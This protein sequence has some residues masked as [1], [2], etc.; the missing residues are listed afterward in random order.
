MSNKCPT[1]GAPA[2]PTNQIFDGVYEYRG[3]EWRYREHLVP[4][5]HL[6]RVLAT[7]HQAALKA[8]GTWWGRELADALDAY[9]T[10]EISSVG[11]P[12]EAL[13][14]LAE[15]WERTATKL[16]TPTVLDGH[17][18]AVSAE[19][20]RDCATDLR[21]AL[22]GE[23]QPAPDDAAGRAWA[24]ANVRRNGKDSRTC[25]HDGLLTPGIESGCVQCAH[26][27]G[28]REGQVEAGAY[29]TSDEAF[30]ELRARIAER[31]SLPATRGG[32]PE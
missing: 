12:S 15:L 8:Q 14:Q 31:G 22:R 5:I 16:D 30:S 18:Y 26:E 3:P 7:A 11:A 32:D 6:T 17:A 9:T 20:L 25:G 28:R 4:T 2:V 19:V 29:L 1:C 23:G 24:V 27:L 10:P 21:A 13:W